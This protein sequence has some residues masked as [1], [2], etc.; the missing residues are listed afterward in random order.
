MERKRNNTPENVD[1]K[2]TVIKP[3]KRL[4]IPEFLDNVNYGQLEALCRFGI[5]N[6][7]LMEIYGVCKDTFYKAMAADERF[8]KTIEH[9]RLL[10]GADVATKYY[11]A[12]MG[13]SQKETYIDNWKGEI[14]EKTYTKNFPPDTKAG[15][16][17]LKSTNP[18]VWVVQ[19][20]QDVTIND[21]RE[22]LENQ[23]KLDNLD[24]A[25]LEY[26]QKMAEK[27]GI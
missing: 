19:E 14:I 6:E 3:D 18:D 8:R 20:K 25:D 17:I 16:H 7:K 23:K 15:A 13:Y 12:A 21:K 10:A 26:L 24:D 1:I 2:T 5:T 22:V 27:T 9:G 4:G 11:D